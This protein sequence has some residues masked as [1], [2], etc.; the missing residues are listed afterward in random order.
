MLRTARLLQS[1]FLI[2]ITIVVQSIQF[3][4]LALS[5]RAAISTKVLFPC[6]QLAFYQ[7]H[8]ARPRQ[9][10][11]AARVGLVFL[12]RWFD[13]RRALTIVQ[14][15]TPIGWHR[16]GFTSLHL[17][18]SR[19]PKSEPFFETK[20]ASQAGLNEPQPDLG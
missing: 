7:E 15:E 19:N 3:L 13:W 11:D 5:S 18:S 14:P 4:R 6:K 9:L 16:K 17:P 20:C 12:S 10:T 8:Q 1:L 2:L